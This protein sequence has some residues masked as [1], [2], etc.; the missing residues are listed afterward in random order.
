MK[1]K[2]LKNDKIA[3]IK[4]T[5]LFLS[6]PNEMERIQAP[7]SQPFAPS[8]PLSLIVIFD[9]STSFLKKLLVSLTFTNNKFPS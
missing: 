9:Y 6:I 4:I 7:N 3:P 5:N 2:E 8:S 1:N